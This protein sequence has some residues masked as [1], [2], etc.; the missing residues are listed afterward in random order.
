M[1]KKEI[2]VEEQEQLRGL[3]VFE[4]VDLVRR[5]KEMRD[6][7][8]VAPVAATASR[9]AVTRGAEQRLLG[10]ARRKLLAMLAARLE[11]LN[12]AD[13]IGVIQAQLQ[14]INANLEEAFNRAKAMNNSISHD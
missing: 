2:S 10:D 5:L 3:T 1:P 7:S 11:T 9:M 8:A 6:V 13:L 4:V 12:D 14:R